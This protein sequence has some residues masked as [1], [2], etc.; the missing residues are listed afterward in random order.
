M[1]DRMRDN[2]DRIVIRQRVFVVV[3]RKSGGGCQQDHRR[4]DNGGN[5]NF[6]EHDIS[7]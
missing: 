7:L 6:L 4:R 5:S 2:I 1:R 3:V